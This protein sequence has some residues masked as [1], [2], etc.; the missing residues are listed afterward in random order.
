LLG[1]RQIESLDFSNYEQATIVQDMNEAI[2]DSLKGKFSCVLD[3]GTPEHVF[4]FPQAIKNAMEIVAIGGH[5]LGV[6]PA[7]NF[8]GHG[9]YQFSPDLYWRIFSEPNG[10]E[11]EEM[12]VCEAR[13][14]APCYLI[15]DPAKLGRRVQFTNSR[16]AYLMV[17]ARR[18]R[19]AEIFKSIPQQAYYAATWSSQT[20]TASPLSRREKLR[21]WAKRELPEPVKRI[22][23]PLAPQVRPL[24]F[25]GFKKP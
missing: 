24:R 2:P 14:D 17:R 5:F 8:S 16:S 19:R 9:F 23:R 10:Y 12:T 13:H 20:G 22:L 1:A 21:D 7:N 11:V 6:V 15:D 4:N 18:L 25:S 3:G